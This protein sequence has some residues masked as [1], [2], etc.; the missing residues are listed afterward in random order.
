MYLNARSRDA[1]AFSALGRVELDARTM[2]PLGT[3][4]DFARVVA[5]NGRDINSR[6][7]H[8]HRIS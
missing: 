7:N 6:G 8:R 3:L 4:R 1:L 2:S 5:F